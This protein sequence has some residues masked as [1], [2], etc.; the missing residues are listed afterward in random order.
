MIQTDATCSRP[1]Q[2]EAIEPVEVASQLRAGGRLS[3]PFSRNRKN[4]SYTAAAV[5]GLFVPAELQQCLLRPF[6]ITSVSVAGALLSSDNKIQELPLLSLTELFPEGA[7]LHIVDGNFSTVATVLS[8]TM[9]HQLGSKK[10][11]DSANFLG[12]RDG[13]S[14]FPSLLLR[15]LFF[16]RSKRRK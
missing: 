13:I 11:Q 12:K 4:L 16:A 8:L 9:Q 10:K 1:L 2:P 5:S 14:F 7:A 6:R 3:E 15:L